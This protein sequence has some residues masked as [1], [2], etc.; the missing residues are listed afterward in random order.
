MTKT[1]QE[2]TIA[3]VTEIPDCDF[4]KMLK[5]SV[6]KKAEYDA[7]S[8][9]K[10]I[11]GYMCQDCFNLFGVGLGTGKGQKLVLIE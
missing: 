8:R 7:K 4:C 2:I 1:A 6:I 5:R 10:G 11:W 9:M 3:K